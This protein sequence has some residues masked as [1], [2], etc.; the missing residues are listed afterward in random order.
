MMTVS[1][2]IILCINLF[3]K[4]FYALSL[5]SFDCT[6]VVANTI[7]TV[8]LNCLRDDGNLPAVTESVQCSIDNGPLF[9][10][11]LKILFR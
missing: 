4:H 8:T 1:P 3:L 10:C 11:E 7:P 5:A 6:T 9:N 2:I